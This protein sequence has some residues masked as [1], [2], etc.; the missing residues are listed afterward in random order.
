M[1]LAVDPGCTQARLVLSLALDGEAAASSETLA[2]ARHLCACR[3]CAQFAVRVTA[4]THELRSTRL[5][6]N[7][8]GRGSANHSIEG[9]IS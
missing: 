2:A 5:E 6:R 8:R 3:P 7:G 9:G 1:R 4:M